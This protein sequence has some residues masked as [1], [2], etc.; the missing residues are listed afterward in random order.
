MQ[1]LWWNESRS[2]LARECAAARPTISRASPC[3][4][5]GS[6]SRRC[7]RSS[8]P[9]PGQVRENWSSIERRSRLSPPLSTA[10]SSSCPGDAPPW[11][12]RLHCSG[13]DGGPPPRGRVDTRAR[14]AAFV[15]QMKAPGVGV[16]AYV[17]SSNDAH[18]A[19]AEAGTP[20]DSDARFAIS[21]PS[22]QLLGRDRAAAWADKLTFNPPSRL[23]LLSL[24]I[25]IVLA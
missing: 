4:P 12:R 9:P 23:L 21:W 7:C 11:D 18:Q 13:D 1:Y 19:S 6:S 5:S 16:D 22:R 3:A 8:P 14:V 25:T 17:V 20:G 24:C 15:S 2:Y 10:T